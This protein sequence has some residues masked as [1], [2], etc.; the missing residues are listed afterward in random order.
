MGIQAM[1]QFQLSTNSSLCGCLPRT[2]VHIG[3]RWHTK[4]M[5]FLWNGQIRP[6][7]ACGVW[8]MAQFFVAMMMSTYWTRRSMVWEC[9][10][11]PPE[12]PIAP[13]LDDENES[14]N[15]L[16]VPVEGLPAQ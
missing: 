2:C 10:A 9:A 8:A 15:R 16:C 6:G 7:S 11:P 4:L 3:H 1:A 14:R 12:L 13:G 5:S